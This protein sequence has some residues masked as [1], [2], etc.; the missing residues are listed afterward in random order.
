MVE[1]F[2]RLFSQETIDIILPATLQ[3][4]Y[5]VFV[6]TPITIFFG[7][8]F[9]SSLYIT[10]KNGLY[11]MFIFNKTFGAIINAVLALPSMIVIILALPLSKF[12]VGV[13]Y[14]PKACI[15]A[16]TIVCT[17][18]FSRLV[19]S[20]ILE[21][22]K[23]KVEA[24]KSMGAST[25]DIILKVMLPEALPSLIRNFV[26]LTITLISITAIAGTFGAGGLGEVAVRFGYHRFR[27]DIL[28]AAVLVLLVLV[29]GLQLLGGRLSKRMLKKRHLI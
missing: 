25:F 17:P 18:I 5:M 27:T 20:S 22:S 12:V 10:D 29:E 14:G 26:V 3:T 28:L 4:L 7:L 19:E 16:L 11:P 24:A 9:G 2:I 21:V 15:I 6:A 1:F 8:V 13:S 23:G